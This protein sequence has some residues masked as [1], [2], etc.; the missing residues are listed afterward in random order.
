MKL[1]FLGANRQVTGSKYC[2]EVGRERVLI[3][4]GLFQERPFEHRNWEACPVP[5][6]QLTAMLLTHAHLDHCG[7]LP[8]L[9][10][11]G[12]NCPIHCTRPTAPLAE[13]VMRDSA[14]IQLEDAQYKQKRLSRQ[15]KKPRYP[16]EPL[17]TVEDVTQTLTLR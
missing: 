4:A 1:H 13:V 10:K 3:D 17:Y 14:E 16:A 15:Q 2:L 12:L 8:R 11:H 5:P 7:L 9:V 6:A